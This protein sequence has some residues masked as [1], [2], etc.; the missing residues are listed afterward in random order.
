MGTRPAARASTCT[1][2][3]ASARGRSTRA[4]SS[5]SAARR[6]VSSAAAR[7]RRASAA[8]ACAREMASS[9]SSHARL[10]SSRRPGS[11]AWRGTPTR[12]S[13]HSP[14]R[15]DARPSSSLIRAS[16]RLA[17]AC[18]RC[19][20][21]CSCSSRA[22]SLAVSVASVRTSRRTR[23][24]RMRAVPLVVAART[25]R[26]S[27]KGVTGPILTQRLP[28]ATDGSA[29]RTSSARSSNRIMRVRREGCGASLTAV[30]SDELARGRQLD[31]IAQLDPLL[32]ARR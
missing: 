18:A 28:A 17:S 10:H 2:R 31:A 14:S 29:L 24:P 32:T 1:S 25:L 11:A 15:C 8:P 20:A 22:I 4:S 3:I 26:S 5:R 30:S 6:S 19:A 12:A 27:T 9:T 13:T 23:T 7:S 21:R 16:R